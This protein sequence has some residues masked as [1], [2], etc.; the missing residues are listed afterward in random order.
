MK[1]INSIQK[2]INTVAGISI[3]FVELCSLFP[4]FII[5]IFGYMAEFNMMYLSNNNVPFIMF[6]II[7]YVLPCFNV[8]IGGAI[9]AFK[10]HCGFVMRISCLYIILNILS[11]GL[12]YLSL[13]GVNVFLDELSKMLKR[14]IF[15]IANICLCLYS[16]K[17]KN[18][19]IYNKI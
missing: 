18:L 14:N 16:S 8:A 11:I 4:L 3:I 9:L 7:D 6:L 13:F 17:Q 15:V 10:K 2:A 1:Y 12:Y 19:C 5:S